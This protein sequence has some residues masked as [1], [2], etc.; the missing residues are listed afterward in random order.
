MMKSRSAK[1]FSLI[2]SILMIIQTVP[3]AAWSET[4]ADPAEGSSD[5][6]VLTDAEGNA[7]EVDESWKETYPY[8]AFAFDVT[9][10]GAKEGEDTVVTV[11]RVGGTNGKAT[12]Y[13]TYQPL[14]VPNEDGSTYEGYALSGDDLTLE[15][16]NPLPI[17]QYQPIGKDPDPER[18]DAV[19]LKDTDEE[20]YVL[21]LSQEAEAYQWEVLYNGSWCSIAESDQSEMKM[22]AEFIDSGE[23]DYRCV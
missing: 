11:Y 23:Y 21:R 20:G 9:A 2:L 3:A 8:G 19:I 15:V 17:A 16:E 4:A 1:L 6:L 10:A 12:A 7:T 22:D 13:L 14:L 18:G 5:N